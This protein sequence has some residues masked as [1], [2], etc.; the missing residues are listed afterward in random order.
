MA[1]AMLLRRQYSLTSRRVI[2]AVTSLIHS[3]QSISF[4]TVK[5]SHFLG[6]NI[7]S[8]SVFKSCFEEMSN[9]NYRMEFR[10][11]FASQA[12]GFAVSDDSYDDK[13]KGDESLEI[14]KL[15]VHQDIVSCLATRGITKLFP[16]QQAV[17]EPAMQ[18]RDMIGRAK[19]G[20]GK[21]L[22]FG[23]PILDKITRHNAKNGA[24]RDPLALVLAPTRELAR[25]VEKEFYESSK[26]D[27]LCVYGGTP[28]GRQMQSLS[29]GVDVIVGTPGRVIDLIKR[30]A[31]NL[32]QV[33][34]VVLDEADQMLNIGFEEDVEV[35][36]EKL[37]QK[38]QTLMFSATMPHSIM[39]LTRKYLKDPLMID[40][41]GDSDQKLAEGIALHSVLVDHHSKAGVIGPLV[42][43]HAN[44]GKTIV[45]TQTKRDADNLAFALGSKNYKC[46]PLHGDIA[47]GQRERTL[48]RFRDGNINILVATDVAARGLDIPNVD[49][50]IHYELPTNSENFV[51]RSG[52]TGRAG[53]KGTAITLYSSDQRRALQ[54]IQRDVGCR[55]HELPPVA[56]DGTSMQMGMGGSN[57]F[58]NSGFTRSGGYG[59]YNSGGY[60]GDS[61]SR[62]PGNYGNMN[63]GGS[64]GSGSGGFS[65]SGGEYSSGG[66][67]GRSNYGQTRGGGFGDF[68]RTDKSGGFGNFGDGRSTQSRNANSNRFG[69]FGDDKF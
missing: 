23:I 61:Y 15:N 12:A 34:F 51:H 28:I 50:I 37:P 31:L 13:S 35:I 6:N 26:L 1:T 45:F 11:S 7:E 4:S 39:N 54:I 62:R 40:L 19:T 47:Q 9:M 59:N 18:G 38:R 55:F 63:F 14:S 5:N 44:G 27:T 25:Q 46:E 29:R 60:G 67:F 57:R 33:Q 30:G 22:A 21:T 24:G 66:N 8:N 56:S 69:S 43:E 36:L 3:N 49:L 64:R 17:L 41:V 10:A 32:S 65:R 58:G 16:I 53:K 68:G 48:K 20:T 42:T 52:R 2:A